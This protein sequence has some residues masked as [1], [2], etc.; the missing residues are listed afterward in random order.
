MDGKGPDLMG[1]DWLTQFKVAL[2]PDNSLESLPPLKE[3]L[4]KHAEV[5]KDQLGCLQGQE[6]K[7]IVKENAQPKCFKPH[8]V[9]FVLRGNKL[10][11]RGRKKMHYFPHTIFSVDQK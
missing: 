6:I 9:P 1:R 3:V 4:E 7:I 8:T 10:N 11:Y 5:F 2:R